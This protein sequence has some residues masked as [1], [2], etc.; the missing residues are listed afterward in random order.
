MAAANAPCSLP[1]R[2][3]QL[4]RGERPRVHSHSALTPITL[5]L[6][7]RTILNELN[8][9]KTSDSARGLRIVFEA[10]HPQKPG[11]TKVEFVTIGEIQIKTSNAPI[12]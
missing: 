10:V 2:H 9:Q 12:Q 6:P 1:T 3:V 5:T 4:A 7:L 8:V 11:A